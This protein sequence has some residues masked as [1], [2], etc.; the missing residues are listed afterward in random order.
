MICCLYLLQ[1]KNFKF[2]GE[3][4]SK[5][6]KGIIQAAMANN[7]NLIVMGTRGL[8]AVG[9]TFRG[10]VS[11]DVIHNSGLPVLVVPSPSKK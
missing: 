3:H 7:A 5:P 11:D 9:R 6:G 1:I 4:H 2:V 8:D 10:S